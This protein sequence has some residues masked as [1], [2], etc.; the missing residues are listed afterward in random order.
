[1][2]KTLRTLLPADKKHI[3]QSSEAES[4]K[5]LR[6]NISLACTAALEQRLAQDVQPVHKSVSMIKLVIVD[7]RSTR[8]GC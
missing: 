1:K 2:I 5:E 6:R 4:S 3:L 7:A 8:L